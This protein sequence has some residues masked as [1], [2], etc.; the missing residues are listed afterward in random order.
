[1]PAG[2]FQ[3]SDTRC[4]QRSLFLEEQSPEDLE[5]METATA[6][7]PR[8]PPKNFIQW[9]TSAKQGIVWR[10][11]LTLAIIFTFIVLIVSARSKLHKVPWILAVPITLTNFIVLLFAMGKGYLHA[12]VTGT[13][14]RQIMYMEDGLQRA[15]AE[16]QETEEIRVNYRK[17]Q[18][19]VGHLE[20][21]N[22]RTFKELSAFEQKYDALR[23]HTGLALGLSGSSSSGGGSSP[24]S[25]VKEHSAWD[26]GAGMETV[27]KVE[28]EFGRAWKGSAWE[29]LGIDEKSDEW[30]V[31]QVTSAREVRIQP[32]E[33][34]VSK[35]KIE[36]GSTL[37]WVFRVRDFDVY[38]S[39]K[40]VFKD[41]NGRNNTEQLL[42][43]RLY[44]GNDKIIGKW[45]AEQPCEVTMT[46]DNNHSTWR[47]K[48]VAYYVGT[49][50]EARN[51]VP[52][53]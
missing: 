32:G 26:T 24:M 17:L 34:V 48:V 18:S 49:E 11:M 39:L 45:I 2:G 10:L 28:K 43:R 7:T 1:M 51:S 3:N 30:R 8:Q 14:R 50:Q 53:L 36:K 21:E 37:R 15:E 47:K 19:Q 52:R 20:E 16:L 25:R 27:E 29:S 22:Q 40:A 42:T 23:S 31:V 9:Y 41:A 6:K 13:L 44:E 4:S 46:F 12:R 38:F 35:I 33:E 5:A